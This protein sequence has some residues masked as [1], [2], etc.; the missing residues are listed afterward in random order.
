MTAFN[1]DKSPFMKLKRTFVLDDAS[2]AVMKLSATEKGRP[3]RA[4]VEGDVLQTNIANSPALTKT[5]EAP[6]S[7]RRVGTRSF[8]PLAELDRALDSAAA[9]RLREVLRNLCNRDD[10][11]RSHV[12]HLLTDHASMAM[13]LRRALALP[14]RRSPFRIRNICVYA[15]RCLQSRINT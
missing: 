14:P 4:L 11:L 1:K 15:N 10:E 6:Q 7:G 2:M 3:S 9:Q 13:N 8:Q 12:Q 5:R